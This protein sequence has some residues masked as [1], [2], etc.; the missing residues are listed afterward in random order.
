MDKNK[1]IELFFLFN[2]F[3]FFNL[4]FCSFIILFDFETFSLRLSFFIDFLNK[5]LTIVTELF[6]II[7]SSL[8]D[9]ELSLL[10]LFEFLFFIIFGLFFLYGVL[11]KDVD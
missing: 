11:S 3:S 9:E 7:L 8:N 6:I 2:I 10:F 4:I 1:F 5:V